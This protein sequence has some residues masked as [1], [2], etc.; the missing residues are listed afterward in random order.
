M[1][2]VVRFTG[3]PRGLHHLVDELRNAGLTVDY[4]APV[5]HR[6]R[7]AD[8]AQTVAIWVTSGAAG[9]LATDGLKAAVKAA[10]R[11]FKEKHP[12]GGDVDV[13]E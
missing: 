8:V 6:S 10:V 3:G 12:Q 9:N 13:D 4:T 7:G 11:K 2:E 1:P 5:E